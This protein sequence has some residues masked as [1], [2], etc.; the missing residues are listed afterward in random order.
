MQRTGT[1]AHL[2]AAVKAIGAPF[3]AA[4]LAGRLIDVALFANLLCDSWLADL[5]IQQE[6]RS[7]HLP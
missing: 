2:A 3:A 4:K 7:G 6:I 5:Y 1:A